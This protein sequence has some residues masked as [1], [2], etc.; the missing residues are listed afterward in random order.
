MKR[1]LL[2]I[3]S[4]LLIASS[5]F[6][7]VASG[8]GN[9]ELSDI[10]RYK[11]EQREDITEFVALL[12]KRVDELEA[13]E[14]NRTE[15]EKTY[16]ETVVTD[17]VGSE[18]LS[19]GQ[20]QYNA[21]A[22]ELAA[23]QAQY[24]AAEQQYNEKLAEYQAAEAQIN[25]AEQ[26]LK[27]AK[28]QRDEA[29]AQLDAATADYERAKPI[30]DL[31]V[32]L[33]SVGEIVSQTLARYGYT[34]IE[35]LKA[36]M[37]AYED[38]QAQLAEA[39]AQ[40]NAAE[41]QL[42]DGKAQLATAK[43]QL[44]EGKAQ[45]D[46][47]KAE[48]DNGKAELQSAKAQLNAGQQQLSENVDKMNDVKEELTAQDDAET[49][50]KEG[51]A[52]L[53][54]NEEIAKLVDDESDYA[55]VLDA[56]R[57]YV[58]EDASSLNAELDTRQSLYNLLRV[59]SVAGVVIGAL[60]LLA[61]LKPSGALLT[62][63]AVGSVLGALGAI[64]LNAYGLA[65]DYR[66][67]VYSLADGTGSGQTQMYAMLLLLGSALLT[68]IIAAV[69]LRAY[70]TGLRGEVPEAAAAEPE[71]VETAVSDAEDGDDDDDEDEDDEEELPR[72]ARRSRGSEQVIAPA[73]QAESVSD[74]ATVAETASIDE[75]AEQTRRL[76]EEAERLENEA[77][78]NAELEKARREY[79]EARR[80]FEAARRNSGE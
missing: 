40:I 2:V 68:A 51:V 58:N 33:G 63:A 4:L 47:A 35:D 41:Q 6:G 24:D 37:K 19:Q 18:Q 14:E 27:E 46:A 10:M 61:A 72:R 54:E 59:L 67:F 76:N 49:A 26:Q 64:A 30:Y 7:I 1:T 16:A 80:R 25:A 21:G 70:K 57:L 79:E 60:C 71:N 43:T 29:Q 31:I 69:C 53:L 17:N 48:L 22:S 28:A 44:D 74:A 45:L 8:S 75:L 15:D 34:S 42:N 9:D 39:N 73:P 5:V 3:M 11:K 62:A 77:R 78:R 56:A 13:N 66:S 32:S 65:K 52:V 55:S 50:V 23:G 12:Q 38:G 36:D 20:A